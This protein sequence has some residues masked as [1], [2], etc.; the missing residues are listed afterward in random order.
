VQKP[1]QPPCVSCVQKKQQI[2]ELK[3]RLKNLEQAQS[4]IKC[5][6]CKDQ[7]VGDLR[8]LI[9]C[10]DCVQ[11]ST[12]EEFKD[13]NTKV[14]QSTSFKHPVC[15]SNLQVKI[16]CTACQKQKED[17]DINHSRLRKNLYPGKSLILSPNYVFKPMKQQQVEHIEHNLYAGFDFNKSKLTIDS[18]I[19]SKIDANEADADANSELARCDFSQKP[20][21]KFLTLGM[22]ND[23]ESSYGEATNHLD[24]STKEPSHLSNPPQA[25]PV[26][27]ISYDS[28]KQHRN[29]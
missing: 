25:R 21:N 18:Y 24:D 7:V 3:D 8:G 2:E 12:I 28:F 29:D 27:E 9:I 1:L 19:E 6:K 17:Q 10:V 13:S 5:L 23:S 16:V 14:I 26:P 20:F 11:Q 4:H 15:S 22:M